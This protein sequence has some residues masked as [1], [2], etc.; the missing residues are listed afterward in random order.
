M[1]TTTSHETTS[2][3][4]LILGGTGKT[5]RRVAKR[6]LDSGA[7][8]VRIASRSA[9]VPFDW[10]EPR[11]WDAVLAGRDI[12]A[13]YIAYYPDV[14]VPDAADH[15]GR[16]AKV[17]ASRGVERIVLLSGR[18][19]PEAIAS[20]EA[21]ARS[22]VAFTILR[23]AF[24][25][26]NFSEGVLAPDPDGVIAFPAGDVGEPFIDAEDIAAVAAAALTDR[27]GQ[28]AS[29]TYDLTG[30][31]LVTFAEAAGEIARATGRAVRYVP[32][33]FDEYARA[34]AP[35]VPAEQVRFFIDLFRGL[36]DGHN[37][38][39]SGDVERVLK[40]APRDFRAYAESLRDGP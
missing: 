1:K 4:T 5:G 26:Q 40:R 6:L 19:E 3:T 32:V 8:R 33:S 2:K 29:R 15:I 11:T 38:H 28:H 12:T 7:S 24:F 34:L 22:G 13:A 37:A 31:R 17:A 18:G 10:N 27:E 21:L 16:F 39:V 20:E 14:A 25:C 23:C 9:E 36:L 30:P 35:H